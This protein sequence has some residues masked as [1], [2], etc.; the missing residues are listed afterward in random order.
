M[1]SLSLS[2]PLSAAS[3]QPLLPTLQ[4]APLLIPFQPVLSSEAR[5][6]ASGCG[7]AG[8]EDHYPNAWGQGGDGRSATAGPWG[9]HELELAENWGLLELSYHRPSQEAQ[10]PFS[11]LPAPPPLHGW[12]N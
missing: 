8:F 11:V 1:I 5:F 3:S 4:L 7:G 2:L 6:L 12:G 9:W 10:G